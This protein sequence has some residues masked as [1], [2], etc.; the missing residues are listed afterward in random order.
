MDERD[1][2]SEDLSLM[3][4]DSIDFIS[5][6]ANIDGCVVM[7]DNLQVLAFG[8][9]FISSSSKPEFITVTD[10]C[11][12]TKTQEI[13]LDEFGTRHRSAIR[14]CNGRSDAIAFVFSSDGGMKAITTVN[15]KLLMWKDLKLA[16][17]CHR[18]EDKNYWLP[19]SHY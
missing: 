8:A 13:S 17:R 16:V 7:T 1:Y 11:E 12:A 4:D 19:V 2:R 6:L 15:S 9:E 14:F 3:I 10:D 5:R 18:D